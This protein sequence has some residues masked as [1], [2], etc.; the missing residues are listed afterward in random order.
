MPSIP[1]GAR[2]RV[3]PE[4]INDQKPWRHQETAVVTA[5]DLEQEDEPYVNHWL[6]FESGAVE[7]FA[8]WELV[9]V[10]DGK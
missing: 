4:L 3:R 1:V 2:V 5:H 7:A 10:E 9:R 8:I 6:E